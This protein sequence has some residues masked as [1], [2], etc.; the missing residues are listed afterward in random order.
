MIIAAITQQRRLECFINV[1]EAARASV[2]ASPGG[3]TDTTK[4]KSHVIYAH[5]FVA[6]SGG[7]GGDHVRRHHKPLL[8]NER[9]NA[10]RP[11]NA[12]GQ[13]TN[14]LSTFPS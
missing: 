10:T 13:Q 2:K 1:S 11:H 3:G 8:T 5:V 7:A 12:A 4:R 9:R 14:T 6:V